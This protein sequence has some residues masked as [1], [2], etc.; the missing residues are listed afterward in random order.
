M[1]RHQESIY[2]PPLL[3][4][5]LHCL[6]QS[7]W[8]TYWPCVAIWPKRFA[9]TRLCMPPCSPSSP[10]WTMQHGM[11]TTHHLLPFATQ[12][13]HLKPTLSGYRVFRGYENTHGDWV[14]GTMATGMVWILAYCGILWTHV[15][16][17]CSLF[18]LTLIPH[19][20]NTISHSSIYS[21]FHI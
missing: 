6:Q 12:H 13:E 5:S 14:M 4:W 1:V 19:Q 7:C 2:S 9:H 8:G 10:H 3:T 21:V 17:L 20:K 16:P 15:H 11:H 18:L